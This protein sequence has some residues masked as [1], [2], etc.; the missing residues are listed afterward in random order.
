M[1]VSNVIFFLTFSLYLNINSKNS[2]SY[3]YWSKRQLSMKQFMEFRITDKFFFFSKS[4]T[5]YAGK[6]KRERKMRVWRKQVK[7]RLYLCRFFYYLFIKNINK[8]W[9][10]SYLKLKL[11]YMR[12]LSFKYWNMHLLTPF[13][14]IDRFQRIS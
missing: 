9:G 10:L 3:R 2:K 12:I 6:K 14:I 7:W 5:S 4:Q 13:V 11:L 8:Q 1:I